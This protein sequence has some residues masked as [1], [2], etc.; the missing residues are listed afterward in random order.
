[1]LDK[2]LYSFIIRLKVRD[3]QFSV[4]SSPEMLFIKWWLKSLLGFNKI[5]VFTFDL[6]VNKDK[7]I[8]FYNSMLDKGLYW[9]IIGLKDRDKDLRMIWSLERLPIK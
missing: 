7:G 1:M 6:W 5:L 9:F 4:I 3:N 8:Y 2:G